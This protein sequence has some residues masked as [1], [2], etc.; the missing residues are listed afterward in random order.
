MR[1]CPLALLVWHLDRRLHLD[2]VART[3]GAL[4]DHAPVITAGVMHA[5]A[6]L[7]VADIKRSVAV[8]A[9]DDHRRFAFKRGSRLLFTSIS[10]LPHAAYTATHIACFAPCHLFVTNACS[11]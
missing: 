11:S 5:L 6:E 4:P 8:W 7:L 2:A 9:C 3:I 1:C 10:I